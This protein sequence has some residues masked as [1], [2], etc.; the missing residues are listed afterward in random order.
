[1]TLFENNLFMLIE[2]EHID[3]Y[4][5]AIILKYKNMV[6]IICFILYGFIISASSEN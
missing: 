6:G 4:C 2:W 1:M 5:D 3:V